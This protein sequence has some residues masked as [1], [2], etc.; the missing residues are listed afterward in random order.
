MSINTAKKYIDET[1]IDWHS[2][3]GAYFRYLI[4]S[5]KPASYPPLWL[6]KLEYLPGVRTVA[7]DI[8]PQNSSESIHQANKFST[9]KKIENKLDNVR[10]I[11]KIKNKILDS[12]GRRSAQEIND[13]NS[14]NTSVCI[15][16]CADSKENLDK[17]TD[18]V[19]ETADDMGI[20][21]EPIQQKHAQAVE[22]CSPIGSNQLDI[23]QR[24]DDE[25]SATTGGFVL[26]K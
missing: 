11:K 26:F 5:E 14:F 24:M 10:I 3:S 1:G 7:A 16:L 6:Q 4:L 17:C 13:E 2:R 8:D 23:S 25:A 15:E 18:I 21:L 9:R 12:F 22:F 19:V 20:V